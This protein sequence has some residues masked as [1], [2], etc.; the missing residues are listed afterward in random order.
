MSN[1]AIEADVHSPRRDRRRTLTKLDGRL[2]L[3]RRFAE[4]IVLFTAAVHGEMTPMRR[5]KVERAAQLCA[6]AEQARGDY[7]RDGRGSL[8]DLVRI[9]R[10]ADSS[11]R[12]IGLTDAKLSISAE[13]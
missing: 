12:A 9:E 8:D 11:V 5:L 7:M 2:P 6:L 10:K 1:L 4:L 3:G 13:I